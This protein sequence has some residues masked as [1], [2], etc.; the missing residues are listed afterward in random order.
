M[1]FKDGPMSHIGN[2]ETMASK[3]A[4]A[5]AQPGSFVIEKDMFGWPLP[6]R[7]KILAHP[8]LSDNAAIWDATENPDLPPEIVNSPNVVTYSK[9]RQSELADDSND[10]VMR[11]AEYQL[12]ED[13]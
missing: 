12:V 3:L 4:G 7:L 6:D 13:A 10:H 11:G 8:G 2:I 9:V 1:R 5:G